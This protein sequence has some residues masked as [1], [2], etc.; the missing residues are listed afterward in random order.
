MSAFRDTVINTLNTASLLAPSGRQQTHTPFFTWSVVPNA[1]HYRVLIG[2][3]PSTGTAEGLQDGTKILSYQSYAAN[4]ICA[5]ATCS[6]QAAI[7]FPNGVHYWSVQALGTQSLSIWSDAQAFTLFT[8]E[9]PPSADVQGLLPNAETDEY[10]VF[11]WQPLKGQA[12]VAD[13]THYQILVFDIEND[14]NK[15][16]TDWI[17]ADRLCNALVCSKTSLKRLRQGKYLWRIKSKT[18]YN[19]GEYGIRTRFTTASQACAGSRNKLL[20]L[21]PY[22]ALTLPDF[23]FVN[24]YY[25]MELS[26]LFHNN[27][28]WSLANKLELISSSESCPSN[29]PLITVHPTH[30]RIQMTDACLANTR[31]EI[32][33]NVRLNLDQ[34]WTLEAR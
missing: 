32:N 26:L 18:R 24:Q 20:V 34:T 17:E 25:P 21:D 9:T 8:T 22:I 23:C 19:E 30:F 13:A 4:A 29:S 31:L 15:Y 11:Y 6:I 12:G 14:E 28:T 2:I 7:N 10:P 27:A 33:D 1:S 3:A 16:E 5:A